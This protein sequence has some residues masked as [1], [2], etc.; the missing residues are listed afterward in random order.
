MFKNRQV[1]RP[2][3]AEISLSVCCE[4]VESLPAVDS[5]ELF[6]MDHNADTAFLS[7]QG[8]VLISDLL[9]AQPRLTAAAVGYE[10]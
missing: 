5:P 10:L 1:Y 4:Y 2:P 3:P 6:G 9:A 7:N 8:R